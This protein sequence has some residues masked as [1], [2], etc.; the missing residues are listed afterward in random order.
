MRIL[1]ALMLAAA[2]P[3]WTAPASSNE[4][5]K[6]ARKA[7]EQALKLEKQNKADA[8]FHKFS[9]AAE[10]DPGNV[11]YLTMREVS[12]QKLV[13]QHVEAGN[14]ALLQN[15]R[16]RAL[17]EFRA[18]SQ[19]DPSNQFA[20][21][22]IRQAFSEPE[23]QPSRLLQIVEQSDEIVLRP[24]PGRQSIHYRGDTRGLMEQVARSFGLS[25]TFD[26]SFN[27]RPVNFD[28]DNV[29]FLE[30]I[31]LA[32]RFAKA[33]WSPLS[34]TQIFVA[35]D[36]PENHRQFDRMSLRTFYL[37]D[38]ATPQEMNEVVSVL[39]GL[40]EIRHLVPNAGKSTLTV[41]APKRILDAATVWLNRLGSGRP[42]VMLDLRVYQVNE[43]MMRTLGV[44]LPL[45]FQIFNIPASALQLVKNPDVQQLIND[46]IASGGLNQANTSAISALLAQLQNQQS[47]PLLSQSFFAFGGGLS[48]FGVVV[49][50]LTINASLDKSSVSSLEH[51]TLRAADGN[52]ATFRLGSRFPVLNGTF[53][54]LVNTPAINDL[55][56][57]QTFV[58]P[59]PSFTYEDLGI[60]LK[61]TP[62]V[63]ES[64]K[65]T[66]EPGMS[67]EVT[68]N[69]DLNLRSLTGTA[70]NGIP[71]IS[72]RQFTS[73]VRLREG[74][75]AVLA[76]MLS[77]S[78]QRSLSGPVGL[79]RLPIL[80]RALS[81][82][83]K[84]KVEDEILMVITPYI[85]RSADQVGSTELWLPAGS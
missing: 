37:P 50:P 52:A 30:A 72:T 3:A 56:K 46:L 41:R 71:V 49:P 27:A 24:R 54:P 18:A 82:E 75:P 44:N 29:D 21:E 35:Q 76:G 53:S 6:S 16:I 81:N 2:I 15:D 59:F 4:A 61:A 14:Q 17:G 70:F 63:H 40:F 85:V 25:A 33:M 7:F 12:R 62:Q 45:Q 19:L 22:R 60:T 57:N 34:E 51:M 58:A 47:N 13:H 42:Q 5:A 10:L 69:F 9:E 38:V 11:E 8:A 67:L 55:L 84:S 77:H 83:N 66:T 1:I 31:S 28:A 32:G 36:T 73:V 79:G 39:R 78:E 80:E 68:L 64:P 43:S 23:S 26:E 65:S 20:L 48:L 74:E